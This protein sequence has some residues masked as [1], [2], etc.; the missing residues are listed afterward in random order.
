MDVAIYD[1]L[2]R[3][4]DGAEVVATGVLSNGWEG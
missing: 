4:C 1:I 3:A 2:R